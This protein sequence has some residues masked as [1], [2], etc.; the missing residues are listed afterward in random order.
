V[1]RPLVRFAELNL[2][3]ADYPTAATGTLAM[4]LVLCRNVLIYF[5]PEAARHVLQ[6]LGGSLVESGWLL[7]SP[8]DLPCGELP[9]LVREGSAGSLRR[10]PAAPPTP[11][12]AAIPAPRPAPTPG[13]APS[14]EAAPGQDAAL[15]H[16]AAPRSGRHPLAEQPRADASA[17]ARPQAPAPAC[18][19][20][21]RR[22]RACADAGDLAQAEALCRQAQAAGGFDADATWLLATILA[23]RGDLPQAEAELERTLFLDPGHVP[24]RLALASLHRRAERP[25]AARRQL[26]AALARLAGHADDSVVQGSGGHT[27]GNLRAALARGQERR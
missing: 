12:L 18:G 7:A 27:A 16:A 2:A 10:Q 26:G 6:R 3:A 20:L 4:D 19:E 24:A 17:A 8:A 5:A 11:A 23:E 1:L 13:A 15:V 25:Q 21:A 14:G 22:A 9:G